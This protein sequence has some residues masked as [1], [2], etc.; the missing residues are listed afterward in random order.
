MLNVV[1]ISC[2]SAKVFTAILFFTCR[3]R[4]GR[5]GGCRGQPGPGT[6]PAAAGAGLVKPAHKKRIRRGLQSWNF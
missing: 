1:I 4:G 5:V 3:W 6:P 2:V